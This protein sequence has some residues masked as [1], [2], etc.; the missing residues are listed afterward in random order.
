MTDMKTTKATTYIACPLATSSERKLLALQCPASLE[1]VSYVRKLLKQVCELLNLDKS[2]INK[3]SLAFSEAANNI[4]E[5]SQANCFYS[6]FSHNE[7]SWCL[8]LLD[9]GALFNPLSYTASI[10]N[11]TSNK[12]AVSDTFPDTFPDTFQNNPIANE[13]PFSLDTEFDQANGFNLAEG[14]RGIDLIKQTVDTIEYEQVTHVNQQHNQL[15]MR[16]SRNTEQKPKLLLVE[17]EGFLRTLYRTYLEKDYV[18]VEAD[19]GENALQKLTQ[20]SIDLVI[21]DIQMPIMDGISLLQHINQSDEIAALPFIFLTG[22]DDANTHSQA[23]YLGIDSYLSKPI[24]KANL[25]NSIRQVLARHQQLCRK[26]TLNLDHSLSQLL[27]PV[28]PEAIHQFQLAFQVFSAPQGGGDFLISHALDNGDVI[29]ALGDVMG[30]NSQA[31]FFAHTF[32]SYLRGLFASQAANL[33]ANSI[34]M[35]QLMSQLSHFIH[36]DGLASQTLLTC[37][38]IRVNA[39]GIELA[40][41]GHPNPLIINQAGDIQ[42]VDVDGMIL[43]LL[44]EQEYQCQTL[45]ITHKNLLFYTDGLFEATQ[46]KSQLEQHRQA[47]LRKLKDCR[48]Q[49]AHVTLSELSQ[50]FS[51]LAGLPV[52]DDTLLLVISGKE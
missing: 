2:L 20:Q 6:Q 37:Q 36:T 49:G 34:D 26:I 4:V 23:S 28:I 16:W 10:S 22:Q 7:H 17:D 47:L 46:D 9:N 13:Q 11:T 25:L 14:G 44:A 42:T 15:I 19:N 21:A 27:K 5:H 3:I 18:V 24:N 29:I 43:G 52:A 33:T 30:H 12:A 38:L 35:G 31:K 41:A 8:T 40:S 45:D 51:Q 50:T 48:Q 1:Q 32:V 39:T